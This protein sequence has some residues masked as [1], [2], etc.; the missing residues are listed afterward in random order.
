MKYW[1]LLILLIASTQLIAQQ[2]DSL[3]TLRLQE[4]K[5]YGLPIT[6]YAAGSK[7]EH[8]GLSDKS[9]LLDHALGQASSLYFKTYGNSQVST[10]AFRGTSASHT[11][12]LWNGININSA[13][14]G[15]TDF[16]LLP[17]F[18]LDEISLQYGTSSSIYGSDAIG[19]SVLI[20]TSKP[21]FSRGLKLNFHQDV[22]SFKN[23][24]S[25][26][27]AEASGERWVIRSKIM[28]R[29]LENNFP[30]TSKAVGHRKIQQHAAVEQYGIDQQV[31]YRIAET[32][33]L[34]LD[35]LVTYNF[36][37]IQPTV[38]ADDNGTLEDTNARVNLSYHGSY[39][40]SNVYG[41]CGYVNEDK[42]YNSTDRTRVH[43]INALFNVDRPLNLRS[44]IRYGANWTLFMSNVEN[45][46]SNLNESRFDGFL[47]FNY[48]LLPVW[49]IS[50]NARQSLYAGRYA[51]L[52]P[53]FGSEV[54][55]IRKERRSLLFRSQLSRGYRVPTLND[56]FWNPGGNPGLRPENAWHTEGGLTWE[57]KE[58]HTVKAEATVYETWTD[59]W[60]LWQP[61]EQGFWSPSNLQ[62]VNSY[63]AE[64][65]V[66]HAFAVSESS[67]IQSGISYSYTRSKNRKGLTPT[68]Q[69]T[70]NTQLP[71]VPYH[72][73]NFSGKWIKNKIVTEIYLDYTG[74]RYTALDNAEYQALKSYLLTG[75]SM[76]DSF[77]FG[78][79]SLTVRLQIDNIFDVYY[80]NVRNLAMPG[81]N[82][83]ASL[84]MKFNR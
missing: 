31:H 59:Q 5:V 76:A 16:S 30:F 2:V 64:T 62:K 29:T 25:G 74:K 4:V 58:K 55:V 54:S 66:K 83:L 23:L 71:Y 3:Q 47:S 60:I 73:A 34:S 24:F 39:G 26:V 70:V 15:Q 18:L 13:S 53:S 14:L 84:M 36:R 65:S 48:A 6:K 67:F 49:N 9:C 19:G 82:Y 41:S 45:Y 27:K 43:Q 46:V 37:E 42:V 21:T 57:R 81:R 44:S 20:N 80:E 50:L 63:G 72:R 79:S 12:V 77:A 51:P 10:I 35:A 17:V 40:Q 56:R 8:L 22:G 11:A 1:I 68:D 78:N 69:S 52:S 38:T 33:W 61:T 28:Y 32:N 75:F 7:I